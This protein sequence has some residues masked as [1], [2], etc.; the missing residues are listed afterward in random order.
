MEDF[1][2]V[3]HSKIHSPDAIVFRVLSKGVMVIW[4]VAERGW[5]TILALGLTIALWPAG[6][7]ETSTNPPARVKISGFGFLGN[8][9]MVRLL[10]HFQLDDRMPAVID[11]TFV[12]DAVLILLGRAREEGYLLAH[13]EGAFILTDGSR[14]KLAWTNALEAVLPGDFAATEARFRLEHGVRFYYRRLVFTGLQAF[15]KRE[16]TSYFVGGETLLKLRGNRVFSPAAL[17][18]SLAALRAAYVRAG[19]EAAVVSTN[20][21]IW[22]DSTGEVSAEVVVREGLP[23]MARLVSARIQGA[24][25]AVPVPRTFKLDKPY[26]PLWQQDLAQTL[27][28]EQQVKGFPDTKVEFAEVRRET[29][30]ANI[31]LDLSASVIPGSFVR[32]GTVSE[33]GTYRVRSSVLRSRIQLVEGD[34]LNVV[35]AEKSR[36]RLAR[37][38]VFDSVRLRYE[39]VDDSTRNVIYELKEGKPVSWSVL[40]GYGSYEKLRGGLEFE[41]RNMFS[42]AHALQLRGVQS[43]KSSSG[44]LLYTVPQ[45]F[46]KNVNL[47]LQGSGLRREEVTFTREEYGGQVGL[48]K[49]LVPLKTDFTIRY[50]YEILDTQFE[51]PNSTNLIGTPQA[52]S[53]A[54]VIQL[55]RDLRDPPLLPRRG[56]KLFTQMEFASESLGGNVNYQR[57]LV[58][59][60]YHQDLGGGRL[61][62]FGAM[63]G[64]TFTWGGT[65]N[66]LPFNK[67]YFPGG[68]NSVRGYVE[69][70]ASPLDGNGQQL[71]AETFTLLNLEL[72]QL[73]T[74]T[75]SVV[76]FI[77]TV[78]FAQYRADYP[79][80]QVLSSVG[81]G[82]NW[83]SLI[84][85]V[86]LEYGYNLNR[87]P[88]DPVGTVHF[89]IG[90]PF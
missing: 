18:S 39:P 7:A 16:A 71:G 49:L 14:Q 88:L 4:A 28:A 36:Q 17:S 29:N 41:N 68:A 57:L 80:D 65:A 75:W 69:G 60:S 23:T 59:A 46:G 21:V 33:E 5:K 27:K 40:A 24:D 8:R 61:L 52:N 9:E 50:D 31:Q 84:G 76:A 67:R 43:F 22:N 11:R 83:R 62:H 19:Y 10:R 38:G 47:F 54:F 63:Q 77:D 87:R 45:A 70:E 53:A 64:M 85:P 90:F 25:E 44:D 13:L 6:A 81:G 30:A 2:P 82:V 3:I 66:Q 56:L 37:L 73:L 32:V 42:L 55:V 72:E 1:R 51:H 79:W 74:K 35:E 86:R 48:Q 26:S 89:S 20:Q 15:S 34:P 78:G 58:G 12:E